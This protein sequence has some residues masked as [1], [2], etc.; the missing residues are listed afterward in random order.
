MQLDRR[1]LDDPELHRPR[2]LR[3]VATSPKLWEN[4]CPTVEQVAPANTPC[5]VSDQP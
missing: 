3:I 1:A 4:R 5:W 2:R